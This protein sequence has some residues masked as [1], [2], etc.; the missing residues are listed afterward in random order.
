M[1]LLPAENMGM[2]L[3]GVE[4]GTREHSTQMQI[5]PHKNH[6]TQESFEGVFSP[7]FSARFSQFAV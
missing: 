1:R 2:A 7:S 4:A 3:E 5:V 6:V